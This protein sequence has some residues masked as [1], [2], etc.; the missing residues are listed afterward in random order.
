MNMAKQ[1]VDINDMVDQSNAQLKQLGV[2]MRISIRGGMFCLRG[3]LPSKHPGEPPLQQRLP[4][5]LKA[6]VA[7]LKRAVTIAQKVSSDV[8]LGQ[9]SWASYIDVEVPLDTVGAVVERLEQHYFASRVKTKQSESTWKTS[10]L[11]VYKRLPPT[12]KLTEKVALDYLISTAPDSKSR[13]RAHM[14][15]TRLLR[16]AKLPYDGDI[17]RELR[18]SYDSKGPEQRELPSDE[19]LVAIAQSIKD[20]LTKMCFGLY[21]TFGLRTHEIWHCDTTPLVEGEGY[22]LISKDTKSK[23][24]RRA[25]ALPQSWVGLLDLRHPLDMGEIP[26]KSNRELGGLISK[27][28]LRRKLPS[29]YTMRHCF[30]ARALRMGVDPVSASKS[31]GHSVSV[32]QTH[33]TRWIADQQIEDAFISARDPKTRA[34]QEP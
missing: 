25:Y 23:K 1:P 2:R 11:E 28:F 10:Y 29:P 32:G 6:T 5:G 14:A 17:W 16:F 21:A 26:D 12:A 24:A 22:V 3:M 8:V 15:L 18:G 33:Y 13:L 7:G 30:R 20:P 19:E 31:M 34:P 27:R 4:L 9:F